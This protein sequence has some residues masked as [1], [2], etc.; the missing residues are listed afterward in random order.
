MCLAFTTLLLLVIS[1]TLVAA[2][3][4]GLSAAVHLLRGFLVLFHVHV[5][6]AGLQGLG[7]DGQGQDEN[8]EL[9][10]NKFSRNSSLCIYRH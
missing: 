10:I 7:V 9:H 1:I 3:V 6:E 5:T 4:P 8:Q 2:V